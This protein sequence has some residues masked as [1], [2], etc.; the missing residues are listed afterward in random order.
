MADSARG[1][2]T[3]RRNNN[4]KKTTRKLPS[5]RNA[6]VRVIGS[7]GNLSRRARSGSRGSRGSRGNGNGAAAASALASL[8]VVPEHANELNGF[9]GEG[10]GGENNGAGVGFRPINGVAAAAPSRPASM[11]LNEFLGSPVAAPN[12]SESRG[13]AALS[14]ISPPLEDK[15]ARIEPFLLLSAKKRGDVSLKQID[16]KFIF[17]MVALRMAKAKIR[18][19]LFGDRYAPHIPGLEDVERTVEENGSTLLPRLRLADR[20]A[21]R[22]GFQTRRARNAS[23]ARSESR[24][25]REESE[26]RQRAVD[27]QAERM[28]TLLSLQSVELVWARVAEPRKTMIQLQNAL[29]TQDKSLMNSFYIV[30]GPEEEAAATFLKEIKKD[31]AKE[32]YKR[33]YDI[34]MQIEQPLQEMFTQI[35]IILNK[36]PEDPEATVLYDRILAAQTDYDAYSALKRKTIREKYSEADISMFYDAIL[37]WEQFIEARKLV[38]V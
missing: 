10:W 13:V 37:N 26:A 25:R 23:R 31:A 16:E 32:F 4:A 22:V 34:R 38:E 5:L 2:P 19:G 27:E 17:P 12:R 14:P 9:G 15:I 8:E 1:S 7:L 35:L 30:D 24:R 18:A 36:G 29:F 11:R 20:L 33:Q 6:A 28:R 21:G 3:G